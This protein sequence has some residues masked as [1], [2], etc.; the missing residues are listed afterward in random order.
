MKMS[1]TNEE[2][3]VECLSSVLI[4]MKDLQEILD[5]LEKT[6]LPISTLSMSFYDFAQQ[7]KEEFEWSEQSE[8]EW[9]GICPA[10]LKG[11]LEEVDRC[12]EMED[13]GRE[14]EQKAVTA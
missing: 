12:R 2:A 6:P 7:V 4:L 11:F 13:V 14:T 1:M 8:P 9:P 3:R 10:N 5:C